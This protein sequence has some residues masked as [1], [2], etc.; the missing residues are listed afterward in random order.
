MTKRKEQQAALLIQ[1]GELVAPLQ[2]LVDQPEQQTAQTRARAS[3]K[4]THD[5]DNKWGQ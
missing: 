5:R 2:N 3:A 1:F 4:F